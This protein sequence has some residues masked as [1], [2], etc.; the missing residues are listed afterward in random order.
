[1]FHDAH[2]DGEPSPVQHSDDLSPV[3]SI[4]PGASA[5]AAGSP[6]KRDRSPAIAAAALRRSPRQKAAPTPT[7]TPPAEAAAVDIRM[8]EP[9]EAAGSPNERDR[10]TRSP[11]PP[12]RSP[13]GAAKWT[14]QD[15]AAVEAAN[16][17][18]GF[19]IRCRATGQP[20]TQAQIDEARRELLPAQ[21]EQ[22][23]DWPALGVARR[24]PER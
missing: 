23:V 14:E 21:H 2:D 3:A 19:M 22:N 8:A 12:R 18:R 17:G 5:D 24:E 15:L 9:A 11:A 7:P 6:G 1:M 13:R 4:E 20:W 10:D 16:A